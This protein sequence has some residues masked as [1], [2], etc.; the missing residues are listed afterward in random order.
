M[1]FEFLSE[2]AAG[3]WVLAP[4]PVTELRVN[5]QAVCIHSSPLSSCVYLSVMLEPKWPVCLWTLK[6]NKKGESRCY[7]DHNCRAGI[8]HRVASLCECMC[9]ICIGVFLLCWGYA[10]H[11]F[12]VWITVYKSCVCVSMTIYYMHVCYHVLTCWVITQPFPF[13]VIYQV[14]SLC[15]V[16]PYNCSMC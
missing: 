15:I 8:P 13:S 16:C 1:W 4:H 7:W 9:L 11:A 5:H 3:W 12:C 2:R 10:R 6:E 14:M